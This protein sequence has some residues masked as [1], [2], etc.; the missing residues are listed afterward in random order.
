MLQS[1]EIILNILLS[2]K[3]KGN[4]ILKY[5]KIS[6]PNKTIVQPSNTIFVA[7]VSYEE[8]GKA[9]GVTEGKDLVEIVIATKKRDNKN[10]KQTDYSDTKFIIK[11]VIKEIRRLLLSKENRD[12][13]RATPVFRNISP[14]YNNT[15][16]F[17]RGHLLVEVPVLEADGNS[18]D[19]AERI[20]NLLIG[21]VET[22]VT[23]DAG[24][25]RK[26]E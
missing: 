12:Y 26:I 1:D 7:V 11:T 22:Y 21:D 16:A 24:H 6:Y 2:E 10:V 18:E 4:P 8:Q 15:F 14:E 3:K 23:D 13:F 5:F 25:T 19:D 17:N 9:Y 20:K